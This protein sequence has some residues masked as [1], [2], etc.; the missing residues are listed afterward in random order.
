[1]T[2]YHISKNFEVVV[3]GA[4]KRRCPR[5]LHIESESFAKIKAGLAETREEKIFQNHYKL[6]S[7]VHVLDATPEIEKNKPQQLLSKEQLYALEDYSGMDFHEI[8]TYLKQDSAEPNPKLDKQ[9]ADMDAAFE[10]VKPASP[11]V[12]YR[13][14]GVH[15]RDGEDLERAILREYFPHSIIELKEFIS[16]SLNPSIASY[17]SVKTLDSVVLEIRA[18]SGISLKLSDSSN[19]EEMLLPRNSKFRVIA[20]RPYVRY[21]QIDFDEESNY[22]KE[23]NNKEQIMTIVLEEI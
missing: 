16:T 9:I 12:T 7:K 19:E 20:V 18:K 6:G 8:N 2:K 22:L 4:T 10:L 23:T 5:G 14:V 1:M 21:Q 3:C 11:Y 17:F 15:L 13:G